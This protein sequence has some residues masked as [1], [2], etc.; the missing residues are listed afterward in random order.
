MSL[1]AKVVKDEVLPPT[2]YMRDAAR[3]DTIIALSDIPETHPVQGFTRIYESVKKPDGWFMRSDFDP[4]EHPHILPWIMIAE[5]VEGGKYKTRLMGTGTIDLI[6]EDFTGRLFDDM[7]DKEIWALRSKE[8]KL[9][10]SRGEPQY[11]MSLIEPDYGDA[12][13]AYRGIF[14]CRQEDKKLFFFV[15]APEKEKF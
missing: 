12:W 6:G 11:S 9:A 5:E 8:I 15:L 1:K 14:P 2:D 3:S 7:A 13:K 4:V 10:A